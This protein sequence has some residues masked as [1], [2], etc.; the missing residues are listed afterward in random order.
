MLIHTCVINLSFIP[1]EHLFNH[2]HMKGKKAQIFTHGISKT[3]QFS[4]PT[5]K[6]VNF[7]TFWTY[8]MTCLRYNIQDDL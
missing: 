5:Q 6:N 7:N 4:F 3:N 1:T 8:K 2:A